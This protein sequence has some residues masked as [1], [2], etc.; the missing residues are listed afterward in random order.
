MD[1]PVAL[2]LVLIGGPVIAVYGEAICRSL[3]NTFKNMGR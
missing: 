3:W 2:I 1:V